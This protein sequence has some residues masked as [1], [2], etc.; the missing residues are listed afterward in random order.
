MKFSLWEARKLMR[1]KNP[2]LEITTYTAPEAVLVTS[3]DKL[4]QYLEDFS[5]V[6][7]FKDDRSIHIYNKFKDRLLDS[8]DDVA[9]EDLIYITLIERIARTG[10][11]LD[12]IE[13]KLAGKTIIEEDPAYK[14]LNTTH[15]K[16]VEVFSNLRFGEK[17]Y[18]ST[19]VLDKLRKI[20]KKD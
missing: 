1:S 12:K 8:I 11:F 18:N 10:T 19:K 20:V 17:K 14:S 5:L 13:R 6:T 16:C 3:K 4:K 9:K 7:Y 2:D 15:I